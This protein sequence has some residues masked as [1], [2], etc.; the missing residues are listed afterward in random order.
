[1]SD[2]LSK[3]KSCEIELFSYCNRTCWFCPNSFVDRR[4]KKEHLSE[5]VYISILEELRENGFG[6]DWQGG[7]ISYSRYNEPLSDDIFFERVSQ[8]KEILPNALLRTNTNGDYLSPEIIERAESS[9]LGL[10]NIQLYP[11]GEYSVKEIRRLYKQKTKKL[12]IETRLIEPKSTDWSDYRG[13][14]KWEGQFGKMKVWMLGRDFSSN[15][16]DRGGSIDSLT[17]GFRT[18]PCS[19]PSKGIYIDWNGNVMPCCNLRSDIKEHE[20]YILGNVNTQS[21]VSCLTN[22]HAC[23]FRKEMQKQGIKTG[24]CK[25]CLF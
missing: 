24:A 25:T 5:S 11:T 18:S 19:Y 6:A 4:S 3:F 2:K 12:G 14:I 10:L 16:V 23:S 15:G 22:N 1:M 21:L 8:A 9:G 13:K 20:G 7:E 17:K